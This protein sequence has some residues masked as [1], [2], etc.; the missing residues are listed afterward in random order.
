MSGAP[1]LPLVE[2]E[3]DEVC[4]VCCEGVSSLKLPCRPIQSQLFYSTGG[5]C[6]SHG[7]HEQQFSFCDIF[8]GILNFYAQDTDCACIMPV[9]YSRYI[10]K[11]RTLFVPYRDLQ[12]H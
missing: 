1:A 8:S 2:Y 9:A 4:R 10:I 11:K 6:K 12:I 5:D 7:H 3:H